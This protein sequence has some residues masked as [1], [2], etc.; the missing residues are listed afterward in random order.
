MGI[1]GGSKEEDPQLQLAMDHGQLDA[2]AGA[3]LWRSTCTFRSEI[4]TG[5][6]GVTPWWKISRNSILP[7]VRGDLYGKLGE[8]RWRSG[9]SRGCGRANRPMRAAGGN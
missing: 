5:I 1:P 7:L 3:L 4:R 2:G 6:T 8:K 9:L